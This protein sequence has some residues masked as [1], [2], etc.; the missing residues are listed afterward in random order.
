MTQGEQ[1]GTVDGL[2]RVARHLIDRP[3]LDARLEER[4]PL[5]VVRGPIGFGKTSLVARWVEQRPAGQEAYRWLTLDHGIDGNQVRDALSRT[6]AGLAEPTAPVDSPRRRL[7]ALVGGLSTPVCIVLDGLG[8]DVEGGVHQ[9]LVGLVQRSRCLR[10]IVCTRDRAILAAVEGAGVDATVIGPDDL[11]F[12]LEEHAALLS[13]HALDLPADQV[14]RLHGDLAGWPALVRV[15]AT[16][17][18]H[19]AGR[20]TVD[21]EARAAA[22]RYLR[23]HVL[24]R[25]AG[26]EQVRLAARL[27]VLDVVTPATAR[28]ASG[29]DEPGPLLD[30]LEVAG[31]TYATIEDGDWAFRFPEVMRAVLDRELWHRDEAGARRLHGELAAWFVERDQP[32]VA[33][34]YARSAGAWDTVLEL[35]SEHFVALLVNHD[36]VLREALDALP[37][38]SLEARPDLRDAQAVLR[39]VPLRGGVAGAALP[40]EHGE[41]VAMADDP[42]LRARLGRAFIH[43]VALRMSGRAEASVEMAARIRTLFDAIGHDRRR[44]VI[45]YTPVLLAQLGITRFLGADLSGAETDFLTCYAESTAVGDE[46]FAYDAA[47][48]EAL[49]RALGGDIDGA[50]R[51]LARAEE[52]EF[53]PP[54][55]WL[56]ELIGTSGDVAAAIVALDRLDRPGAEAAIARLADPTGPDEL[57]ALIAHVRT[58]Y[59]LLWGDAVAQLPAIARARAAH[60][61]RAGPGTLADIVLT[62]DAVDLLAASGQGMRAERALTATSVPHPSLE[63]ARARIALLSGRTADAVTIATAAVWAETTADRE[64]LALLVL[65]ALAEDARGDR[66]AARRAAGRALSAARAS[67]ILAAFVTVPAGARRRLAELLDDPT[68]VTASP[69]TA[70][71]EVFPAAL[72]IV[73]LSEREQVVLERLAQG[74][75]LERIAELLFVSINTVKTQVRAIYRKLGVS[76]RHAA[77]ARAHELGVLE[78][79]SQSALAY[80]RGTGAPDHGA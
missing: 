48:Y 47:T 58:R 43:A 66:D 59:A 17:I 50:T 21:H 13:R 61:G 40:L 4:S 76:S 25:L 8:P 71:D 39:D 2:P 18:G 29:L 65:L 12:D 73:E 32:E 5:T 54:A 33:L 16:S 38:A 42:N 34:R 56:Q 80:Q 55:P 72:E 24:P 45:D 78:A 23:E 63:V 74:V 20:T 75:N 60:P 44:E 35:L 49:T 30:G 41:L 67:G 36:D 27:A 26:P 52:H 10:L 37:A 11:R 9:E 7:L 68:V 57:W 28:L 79:G 53:E 70:V 51:W 6:L 1:P 31:V 46:L 14:A 69:V 15:A 22:E 3:R 62:A 19:D 77:V 64:R